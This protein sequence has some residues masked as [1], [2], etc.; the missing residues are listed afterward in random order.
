MLHQNIMPFAVHYEEICNY[1]LR[2][3]ATNSAKI[4]S[5]KSEN[6]NNFAHKS[7]SI[8]ILHLNK[9]SNCFW[10]FIMRHLAY[11]REKYTFSNANIKVINTILKVNGEQYNRQTLK[12]KHYIH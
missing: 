7:N 8:T 9:H 2:E 3:T 10:A 6:T 12:C 11:K 1:Y 4:H 5:F